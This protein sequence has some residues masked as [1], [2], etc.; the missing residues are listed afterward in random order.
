MSSSL[1]VGTIKM[2]EVK[3]QAF[4]SAGN[5]QK[6]KAVRARQDLPDY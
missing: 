1:I 4:A 3:A 5:C 2:I 6:H